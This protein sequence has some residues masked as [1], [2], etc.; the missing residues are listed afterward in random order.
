MDGMTYPPCKVHEV[1]VEVESEGTFK[2]PGAE[3]IVLPHGLELGSVMISL[4]DY[5]GV[6]FTMLIIDRR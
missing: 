5:L 6:R 2:W 3:G 1:I 4:T